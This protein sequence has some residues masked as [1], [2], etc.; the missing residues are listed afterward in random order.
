MSIIASKIEPGVLYGHL[1]SLAQSRPNSLQEIDEH[2][3]TKQ[4]ILQW[5]GKLFALVEAS[6]DIIDSVRLRTES[7]NLSVMVRDRGHFAEIEIWAILERALAKAE[8][9]LPANAQ[10][11]FFPVGGH[12]DTYATLAKIFGAAKEDV[13]VI[14][15]YLDEVA[16]TDF[17]VLVPDSV[18]IRLLCDGANLK[19]SLK[20]GVGRWAKQYGTSRPIEARS[21]PPR[22]LHDRLII[23]DNDEVWIVTQSFKDFA[24]RSPGS[25]ER[26]NA[27]SSGLK[28]GAYADMWANG[29]PL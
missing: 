2:G 27:E 18:S 7:A 23:L 26:A 10:G 25:I 19:P 12:L 4:E 22:K 29:V 6:G 1:K 9:S 3:R 28:V 16:L 8:L 20:P 14:D 5:V 11:G 13:F 17:L 21:T 15:P 24:A